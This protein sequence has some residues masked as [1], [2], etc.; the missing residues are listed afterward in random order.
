MN[1]LSSIDIG[2]MKY[3]WLLCS[4]EGIKQMY[5]RYNT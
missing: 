3:L 5:I 2:V 4:Q 1:W